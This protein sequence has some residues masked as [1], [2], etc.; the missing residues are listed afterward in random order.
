MVIGDSFIWGQGLN[1]SQKIYSLT[2]DWL[3]GGSGSEGRDD[4]AKVK[5]HSG[6]T[7][8]FRKE[9]ALAYQRAGRDETYRYDPEVNVGFPSMW[10]QVEV[11]AE[12]YRAAG[13][14][15]GA[16]LILI[17]GGI[18]DISVA[19]LLDPFGDEKLL[20]GLIERYCRDDM[21]D[22]LE[23]AARHNPNA[24]IAVVGYFPIV[25]NKTIGSRLF[26]VADIYFDQNDPIRTNHTLN[27]LYEPAVVDNILDTITIVTNSSDWN[28][29]VYPNPALDDL[30]VFSNKQSELQLFTIM[31]QRKDQYSLKTGRNT[32]NIAQLPKGIYFLQFSSGSGKQTKRLIRQ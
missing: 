6:A 14:P 17:S 7:I 5:A 25:S 30:A 32:I 11:A 15:N 26:N 31:G 4:A 18:T 12:E 19:K 24:V 16:D 9:E 8:K 13:K 22:L 29:S 27:T 28:I 1:E 3:G 21:F 2:A 20:P 10:K 23:H